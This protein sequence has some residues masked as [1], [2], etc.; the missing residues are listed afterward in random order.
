MCVKLPSGYL[1]PGPY[2]SHP[3]S[4]YTCRVTIILRVCGGEIAL[5]RCQNDDSQLMKN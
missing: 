1:N 2:P 4:T 3:T 5:I